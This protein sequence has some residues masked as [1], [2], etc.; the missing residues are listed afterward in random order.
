V[1]DFLTV[2]RQ[3]LGDA[4]TQPHPTVT[5]GGRD[6]PASRPTNGHSTGRELDH[7]RQQAD[8][9]LCCR[10]PTFSRSVAG[11]PSSSDY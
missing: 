5:P 8:H 10:P 9:D 7:G 4:P 1:L 3:T 2:A 11:G 6:T